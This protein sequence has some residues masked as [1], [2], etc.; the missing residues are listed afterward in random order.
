MV[1]YSIVILNYDPEH[2]MTE[3]LNKCLQ[4]IIKNS[5][6]YEE[7]YELILINN[8]DGYPN[9]VNEGFK[10]CKGNFLIH[11]HNDAEVE[12]PDW[13]EKLE[14]PENITGWRLM[15][16]GCNLPDCPDGA[17]WC[18]SRKVFEKIGFMDPQFSEGYGWEDGDYWMRATQGG[19]KFKDAKVKLIHHDNKTFENYHPNEFLKLYNKNKQLFK[20]KWREQLNI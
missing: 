18:M 11:L 13:L 16:F 1:R 7:D 12:D 5:K 6:K 3:L 2:R 20:C 15:P 10:R 9:A 4:G 8:V 19:I 14:D 17:C